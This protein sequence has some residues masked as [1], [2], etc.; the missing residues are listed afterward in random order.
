MKRVALRL[1]CALLLLWVLT[2][3][4]A[5]APVDIV[6]H[7]GALIQVEAP[8]RRVAIFPLPTPAAIIATDGS[9]EQL[10]GINPLA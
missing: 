2:A 7:R 4:A 9:M 3:Q 8:V 1:V 5:A 10:A 6:D